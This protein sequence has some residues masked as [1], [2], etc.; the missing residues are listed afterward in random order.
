LETDDYRQVKQYLRNKYELSMD[1]LQ[2]DA[3]E[4]FQGLLHDLP[5]T[6]RMKM[7]RK[8][9]RGKHMQ[10]NIFKR[11][12]DAPFFAFTVPL[13]TSA[14]FHNGA[15]VYIAGDY[16]EHVY[17]LAQGAVSYLDELCGASA[18]LGTK[19]PYHVIPVGGT[20][21]EYE[22][23]FG[24]PRRCTTRSDTASSMLTMHK[25][26]MLRIMA[27]FPYIAAGMCDHARE[28]HELCEAARRGHRE[29]FATTENP[30]N[31]H[32]DETSNVRAEFV[33]ANLIGLLDGTR[34]TPC[35]SEDD[36]LWPEWPHSSCSNGEAFGEM[37]R[38]NVDNEDGAVDTGATQP[39]GKLAVGSSKD[40]QQRLDLLESA[41]DAIVLGHNRLLSSHSEIAEAMNGM[42]EAIGRINLQIQSLALP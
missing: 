9:H 42:S 5:A 36:P 31:P 20:F 18:P 35:S 11:Y 8:M 4:L 1:W 10:L 23:L 33:H 21:G 6:L 41:V 24:M 32:T 29:T 15:C 17:F 30:D 2:E 16:A 3:A 40:A 28:E 13:M 26:A 25:K 7:L 27:E 22:L 37:V 12:K 34:F 14:E 39:D 38:T 19:L